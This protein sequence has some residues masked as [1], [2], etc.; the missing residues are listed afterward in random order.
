MSGLRDASAP[1]PAAIAR[2]ASVDPKRIRFHWN[3][4]LALDPASVRRRFEQRFAVPEQ[5]RIAIKDG[6]LEIAGSVPYE[7]LERVRR[8]AT[9]IPGV[10]SVV[11]TDAN[12]IYDPELARKRFEAA[13][14]FAGHRECRGGQRCP[15]AHRRSIASVAAAGARR[16]H[17]IAWNH[18]A[19]T[20]V[21]ST[22]ISAPSTN[23]SRSSNPRSFIS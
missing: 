20:I 6:V 21:S 8:E 3:D 16:G 23:P 18:L 22:S 10:K 14:R 15:D 7:W 19:A 5:T 4:Y 9:L 13:V 2:E 1:D 12:I 17:D 11:E